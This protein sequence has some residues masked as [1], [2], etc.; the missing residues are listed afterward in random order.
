MELAEAS[1]PFLFATDADAPPQSFA[2]EADRMRLSGVAVK[3][4]RRVGEAWGLTN[5]PSAALLGVSQS[6][7]ERM[8]RGARDE[9]LS[10]D[11]LTRASAVIGVF[12]GLSLL[13]ADAMAVRWP[14]LP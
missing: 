7:W 14:S 11:Q 8:K 9:V 3:A 1:R 2:E 6:T 13:F 10:Q 4:F 5:A 12:K